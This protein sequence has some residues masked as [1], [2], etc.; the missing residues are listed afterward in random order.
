VVLLPAQILVV[1]F[2]LP[3][4][5]AALEVGRAVCVIEGKST[6]EAI[7]T[8]SLILGVSLGFALSI[9]DADHGFRWLS[10]GVAGAVISRGWARRYVVDSAA[11]GPRAWIMA[12]T[13]VTGSTQPLVTGFLFAVMGPQAA[14]IFK[15]LSTVS[16]ALAPAINFVRLRLLKRH[17]SSDLLLAGG[18]TLA[19]LWLLGA[20]DVLG[21][22]STA[23]GTAWEGVSV[24]ALWV[25]CA[26]RVSSLLST[27]PFATLRRLGRVRLLFGL[28]VISTIVYTGLAVGAA[29]SQEVM[30]IFLGMMVAE[31]LSALLYAV[32]AR[33]IH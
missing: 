24:A 31:M 16:G 14:V 13:L 7:A 29:V 11:P 17:S 18:A 10:L 19:V 28:R 23:F 2:A 26:W 27:P 1:S 4:W 12:D 20:L 30:C 6:R 32:V 21:I 9:S 5:L 22:F 33:R 15:L 25:A 8:L 3:F